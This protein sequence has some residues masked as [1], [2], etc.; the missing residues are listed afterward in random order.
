MLQAD[1]EKFNS[2]GLLVYNASELSCVVSSQ[3]A[4]VELWLGDI[5]VRVLFSQIE[6]TL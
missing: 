3:K 2:N 6:T 5:D 1:E 4:I